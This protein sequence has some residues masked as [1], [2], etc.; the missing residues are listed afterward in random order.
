MPS[1]D[2]AK[3]SYKHSTSVISG[4]EF[5][6]T[7]SSAKQGLHDSCVPHTQRH[8]N[9]EGT[10]QTGTSRDRMLPCITDCVML[11]FARVVFAR[12]VSASIFQ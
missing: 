5:P 4:I 11:V 2:N 1:V 7:K 10:P 3:Q 6:D 12:R 9:N 8:A